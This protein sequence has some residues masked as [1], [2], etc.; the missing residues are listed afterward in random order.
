LLNHLSW[1][2]ER[3]PTLESHSRN[4]FLGQNFQRDQSA[5]SEGM[6]ISCAF[7]F[8][9]AIVFW[10]F[11]RKHWPRQMLRWRKMEDEVGSQASHHSTQPLS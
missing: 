3:V 6:L 8:S 2:V 4:S 9:S 11:E 1:E 5:E 10:A 7:R